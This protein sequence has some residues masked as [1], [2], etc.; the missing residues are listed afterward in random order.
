LGLA[1]VS[2]IAMDHNGNVEFKDNDNQAGAKV[3]LEF[4]YSKKEYHGV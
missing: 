2:K 3:I 4:S 1:I